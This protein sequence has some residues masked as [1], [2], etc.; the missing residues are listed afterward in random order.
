MKS[1]LVRAVRRSP[2]LY[3]AYCKA[4]GN[5]TSILV[6][7]HADIVLEGFGGSGNTFALRAF[8]FPQIFPYRVAHHVHTSS[9]I[10]KGVA[11]GIP[12]VVVVRDPVDSVTSLVSRRTET[13]DDSEIIR[14]ARDLL[15][16]YAAYHKDVLG[17]ADRIVLAK[18][19]TAVSD[20]G[21]IVQEVNRKFNA[22][23]EVFD[24]TDEN[25]AHI[26]ERQ[27]RAKPGTQRLNTKEHIRELL[28]GS[29]V[30]S[31]RERALEAYRAAMGHATC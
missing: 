26:R 20:F 8:T 17:L 2:I 23:F 14:M 22:S 31:E 29:E 24:H 10:R 9:Q 13:L 5:D 3:H 16:R 1:Q 25:V 4:T 18:F 7:K 27:S 11:L 28:A 19:E 6:S 30:A 12:V 15:D 21:S